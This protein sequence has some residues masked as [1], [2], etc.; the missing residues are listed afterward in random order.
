VPGPLLA[1]VRCQPTAVETL[2][3]ALASGRVH[4]AYLFDGP[5]GVGKE[6][7]AF[8]LA[9]SL[10]C[11]RRATGSADA[12]GLCSACQRAIPRGMRARSESSS[13][14]PPSGRRGESR[15]EER[16]PAHP[17]VIVL[18]RGL[19]DP[20]AIGRRSP[21]A[22]E[23]S[24]DQVRTLVLARAAFP[25]YE[26]RAKVFIVR[27]ADELSPAAANAL[28]KTLEEPGRRTHFVLLSSS[29]DSLLPTVRSRTQRV[30]FAPLP[31]E[32]VA[33]LLVEH[34]LDLARA[35]QVARLAGG[36]MAAA[37]VLSDA[38]DSAAREDFVSRAVAA[39]DAR[40]LGPAFDLAE[41]AKKGEKP[42]L[43]EHLRALAEA[44]AA[45]ARMTAALPDRRADCAAARCALALAAAEEIEQ[46]ASTQ[47]AVE[48]ML[49]KM[50]AL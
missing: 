35:A 36:S 6:R 12:C 27:R 17:D 32:T 22:Q 47:L 15:S 41:D 34:G 16:R 1:S 46:N 48:S 23:I 21:E 28:L 42:A 4:H 39:V 49:M 2:R 30:R 7:A 8:G 5:D 31:D 24:I 43:L 29:V 40:H 33:E 11:E 45:E 38:D 10:V 25:P 9:Q 44:L 13:A 37:L 20:S 3:R 19:Y 50:R 26:G 18:E 14:P